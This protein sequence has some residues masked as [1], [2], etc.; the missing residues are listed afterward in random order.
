MNQRRKEEASEIHQEIKRLMRKQEEDRW[1]L[2]GL[3]YRAKEERLFRM[4]IENG[5]TVRSWKAYCE[6]LGIPLSTA[7]ASAKTYECWIVEWEQQIDEVVKRLWGHLRAATAGYL[8]IKKKD[9]PSI[10][11]KAKS[12]REGGVDFD[13]FKEYL[14]ETYTG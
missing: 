9:L 10:L 11:E 14:K 5:K 7:N 13:A 12:K 2:A 3:L 1:I 4:I 6:V 8:N